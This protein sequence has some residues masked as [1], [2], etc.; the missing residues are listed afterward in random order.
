MTPTYSIAS[1]ARDDYRWAAVLARDAASDGGFVYGVRSTGIYCRPSCPARRP[2]PANVRF[3][4]TPAQA[5]AAGFRP[6]RRCRPDQPLAEPAALVQQVRNLIAA[7]PD[8]PSLSQLAAAVGKSRWHVQRTFKRLTGMTPRE[9]AA[10]CRIERLKARLRTART[11]SEA[12]YAAGYGSSSR[13]YERAQH[14]LGMTPAAYRRGGRGTRLGYCIRVTSLGPLLVAGSE[15]G[16]SLV[17]FGHSARQLEQELRREFP[18]A[19]LVADHPRVNLWAQCLE[20]QIEGLRPSSLLPLDLQATAF[21][22]Q[23]WRQLLRIPYGE[24]RSYR[25][26]AQAI[27]R[28]RAVRAV[29]QACARNPVVVAIPC[30]RVIR[31]DGSLGGYR[32]GLRRKRALLQ[33]ERGS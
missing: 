21:Q 23:V 26:V 12:Q 15:R 22:W 14:Y 17:R 16:L 29:A 11:V 28:P 19:H 2:D 31:S 7:S 25:Q 1:T 32:F 30:H 6:C 27:G 3:F 8:T 33:K 10:A 5:R 13:L 20:A 4:E 18:E 9:Y 24:T